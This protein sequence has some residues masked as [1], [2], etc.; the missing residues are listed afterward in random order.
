MLEPEVTLIGTA[1]LLDTA[2][3]RRAGS[4]VTAR[5]REGHRG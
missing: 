2:Q 3:P 5:P 4:Q 1:G